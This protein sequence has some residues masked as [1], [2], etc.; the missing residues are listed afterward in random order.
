[1]HGLGETNDTFIEGRLQITWLM[2]YV[3]VT[4]GGGEKARAGR[5]KK[6]KN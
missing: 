1:M 5:A 3:G 6:K 2:G 4:K